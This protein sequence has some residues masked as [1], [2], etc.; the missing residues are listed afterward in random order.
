MFK[1]AIAHL[2]VCSLLLLPATATVQGQSCE[3]G[4]SPLCGPNCSS[5]SYNILWDPNFDQTSCNI[6]EFEWGTERALT[7][8]MCSG[9]APP[10]ARFNGPSYFF[11][12]QRF[13]QRTDALS[14]PGWTFFRL[15]YTYDINDP[16]NNPNTRLEV[17][18]YVNGVT[19]LV[20]APPGGSQW[21]N[22]RHIDLGSNPDWVGKPMWV[23]F[24]ASQPGNST[25]SVSTTALW[26]SQFD[27][28]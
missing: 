5:V 3:Q 17:T 22:T 2:I 21:C 11:S 19:Y 24:W 16:L 10:F 7:G 1:K 13:Q 6:W 9:W 14:I 8:T 4:K 28:Y 20:D 25:I 27:T 18:I 23:A 12:W 15:S 26:Q